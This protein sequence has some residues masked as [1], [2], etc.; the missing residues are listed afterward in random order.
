MQHWQQV[1]HW[2]SRHSTRGTWPGLAIGDENILDPTFENIQT[3][4]GKE[5]PQRD[6]AANVS[7]SSLGSCPGTGSAHETNPTHWAHTQL[8]LPRGPIECDLPH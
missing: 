6:V 3:Q 7:D 8:Y 2:N 4:K 5:T 1:G